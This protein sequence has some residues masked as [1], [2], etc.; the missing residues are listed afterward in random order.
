[1][2]P[3]ISIIND[4]LYR[5]T[6]GSRAEK[7]AAVLEVPE[8]PLDT[9]S[10]TFTPASGPISFDIK[11]GSVSLNGP[12]FTLLT[13]SEPEFTEYEVRRSLGGETKIRKT[14]DGIKATV[15]GAETETVRTSRHAEIKFFFGD[16][17]LF[18]LGSHEEGYPCLNGHVFHMIQENLRI[19]V[20]MFIS[21]RGYAVLVDNTSYMKFD[22]TAAHE[23]K[24]YIDCADCV[25]IYLFTG[26]NSEI[27]AN[28]RYLTGTTP[29]L[30]KWAFGYIQ[31]KERYTCAQELVDVVSEY[32]RRGIPLDGIVQDWQYWGA[33]LWGE[34]ILDSSRY[35]DFDRYI[36]QI[37]DMGAHVMISIWP[38]MSGDGENQT[39]FK[40]AGLLL[41]DGSVYNAF[42][43]AGRDMYWK[44]ARDGLFK[45]GIDAWWCDSSEPYDANWGGEVRRPQEESVERSISEFK[46]YID[47]ADINAYSLFHSR[48]IYEHQRRE[49]DKRVLNLTRSGFVGQHRYA[50]V[51]WSGDISASWETLR[52]QV[53]ILQNYISTGEAYWNC[54]IGGF[55]VKKGGQWFW[56]GEY[57]GGCD[58]ADYRKLYVRWLQFAAF[59]PMM[60]SHGADTPREIWRFGEP[61]T[62][63]YD[64]IKKAIELRYTLMPYL[65][66]VGAAVTLHGDMPVKPLALA[67]DDAN[68][69]PGSEGGCSE[70]AFGEYLY[71][72]ELLICPV[73]GPGAEGIDVYL[74]EGLWYDFYTEEKYEGG[75]MYRIGTA[76]DS[77]PVFVKAGSIIPMAPVMQYCGETED[78][79]LTV[80]VYTGA[81]GAFELYEDAGD[82]YAYESGD[83]SLRSISYSDKT[84]RIDEKQA[85]SGKYE[86]R[87]NYIYVGK[88]SSSL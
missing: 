62:V 81:E 48:G 42:D 27:Y 58:D 34:K 40:E 82:G 21:D 52:R 85:G 7:S 43:E 19:A 65:Y 75:R 76:I 36:D 79:D 57:E 4:N 77:I 26:K 53:H 29:M 6:Y 18:G 37:H 28:Y 47:D 70:T 78:Y 32:R 12:D 20:P 45:Y 5:I 8:K 2:N 22:F 1:M 71:G 31:S 44:Q 30:P 3:L 83:Y 54:D 67:F 38:N 64:A 84:G 14:V 39:E 46:K 13:V 41:R 24:L 72:N 15:S 50:T 10:E 25:D 23:A 74:P 87:I 17:C 61:G 66:S 60:R 59:T 16:D 73:T 69:K 63:F 86:H 33:N 88:D 56:N 51:T 80:K 55:F 68:L 9:Q 35:A 49:S 11:T